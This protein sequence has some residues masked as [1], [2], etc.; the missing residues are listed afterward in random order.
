MKEPTAADSALAAFQDAEKAN[1]VG[2]IETRRRIRRKVDAA[3]LYAT[4]A[5]GPTLPSGS[6][7]NDSRFGAVASNA[8]G[9]STSRHVAAEAS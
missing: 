9:R 8:L 2:I 3:T 5:E 7:N 6:W 1:V 4:Q